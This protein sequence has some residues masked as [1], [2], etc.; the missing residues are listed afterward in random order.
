MVRGS[1]CICMRHT[2]QSLA[3]AAA[4][5]PGSRN[6]RTSLMNPAPAALAARM[7]S[8]LLVSTEMI[9]AVA[10]RSRSITGMTRRNSSSAPTGSAP[11]RV[12]SPPTSMSAAPSAAMRTP[13]STAASTEAKRPP[14]E[15]ESGVTFSTPMTTGP[16]RSRVLSPQRSTT[17]VDDMGA[18]GES[19]GAQGVKFGSF[20]AVK[21]RDV[22][23]GASRDGSTASPK[24]PKFTPSCAYETRVSVLPRRYRSA[25]GRRPLRRRLR[26]P[27]GQRLVPALGRLGRL[28]RHEVLELLLVD[29]FVLHERIGHRVQFVEGAGEDLASAL[30][31]ALDDPA[32]LL[33]DGVRG[34]V[35][36]L[37]V[38][39]DAATEEHLAGLFRV[40]QRPE[41]VRQAPLGDHVACEF[42]GALDVVRG[43]GGHGFGSKDQFL[44]DAPA[45]QRGYR[46][47]EPALG[48]AIAILLGQ[49]L[50][51]PERPATRNDRDLVHRVVLRDRHADDRVAGLVIGRHALFGLAH[52]HG[53]PLGAHQDLVLGTLE[54]VHADDA[55]VGARGEQRRLV[56]EIGEVRARETGCAA[57]DQRRLHVVGERHAAHV[58]AQNL[59]TA[60]HVGQR[61][62]DLAVEAPRA[63][64]RRIEHVGTV[65]RR[66]DD[67]ALVALEAVHFHQQLIEGL[68]ALVVTA[69][70]ARAAVP[71]DGVDLI[72]EDDAGSVLLRL[73][74]HVAHARGADAD[75]HLDK[76]GAGDG[77]E[78]HL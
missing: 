3:A 73:L 66:D 53:A 41:P 52:D 77:E 22:F 64:Q 46:A 72:D 50:R 29:G 68:L 18:P 57:R 23:A 75:E 27:V 33:V 74:E 37:L 21:N 12:D 69:A 31:V 24:L 60:A 32:N 6:A 7:T 26:R 36:D 11:G 17:G 55:L 15:K 61:H 62:D 44:G 49:E 9:A 70:E 25:T 63:Q 30:V 59:L 51:D 2:A 35:R 47:L 40:G 43:A 38:L 56:D 10:A 19:E 8:A 1:P 76:V 71:A 28:A 16:V 14:S 78:R 58:H 65:G 4:S 39:C 67:D 34:H 5:A 48:E 45:E 42:G 13:C 54:L 20:G